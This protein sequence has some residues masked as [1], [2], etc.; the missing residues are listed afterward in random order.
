[1]KKI[2]VAI[3]LRLRLVFCNIANAKVNL[4]SGKNEYFND[5]VKDFNKYQ[6]FYAEGRTGSIN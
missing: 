1:M 2:I 4:Q 3:L 5:L 6:G